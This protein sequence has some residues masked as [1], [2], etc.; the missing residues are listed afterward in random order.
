MKHLSITL[1]ASSVTD[2][3][4]Q[5]FV[6]VFSFGH[7]SVVMHMTSVKT[8]QVILFWDSR[9]QCFALLVN[10]TVVALYKFFLYFWWS[11]FDCTQFHVACS[12]PVSFRWRYITNFSLVHLLPWN[13]PKCLPANT[14]RICVLSAGALFVQHLQYTVH[15]ISKT[16]MTVN[17]CTE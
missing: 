15:Q 2:R 11:T 13:G 9:G 12:I 4:S 1:S 7:V 6:S 3:S 14:C 8:T 10:L 17:Y 5:N 16:W